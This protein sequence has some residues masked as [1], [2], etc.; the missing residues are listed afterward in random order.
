MKYIMMKSQIGGI[1]RKIPIIFP[2]ILVHQD[3]AEAIRRL[4]QMR[5]SEPDSA[6]F[7]QMHNISCHGESETLHIT[8]KDED[9]DIISTMDY[10]HGIAP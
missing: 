5:M 8:A 3:V 1:T 7:I 10:L 9:S 4:P 2:D 6:G